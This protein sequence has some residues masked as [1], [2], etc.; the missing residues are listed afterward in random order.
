MTASHAAST[1]EHALVLGSAPPRQPGRHA[2][3]PDPIHAACLRLF[4]LHRIDQADDIRWA[5]TQPPALERAMT[6]R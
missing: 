3:D 4:A 5:L 6:A 1:P 2:R